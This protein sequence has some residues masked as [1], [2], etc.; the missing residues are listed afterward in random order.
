MDKKVTKVT[1]GGRQFQMRPENA[2]EFL[3]AVLGAD[4][5]ALRRTAESAYPLST[6]QIALEYLL[7]DVNSFLERRSRCIGSGAALAQ[8]A[9]AAAAPAVLVQLLRCQDVGAEPGAAVAPPADGIPP[10]A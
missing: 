9:A 5:T 2:Q 7:R 6:P 1:S 8:L 3:S 10:A 4:L